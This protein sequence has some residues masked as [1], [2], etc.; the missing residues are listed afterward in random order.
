MLFTSSMGVTNGKWDSP[1]ETKVKCIT[2]AV[3]GDTL[4]GRWGVA[5][6]GGSAGALLDIV[7]HGRCKLASG[8]TLN[9]VVTAITNVGVITDATPGATNVDVA[10]GVCLDADE[11][12]IY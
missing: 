4:P 12:Y 11:M 9:N 6:V 10:V 8:G 5:E 1:Y 7:V 2:I 3:N